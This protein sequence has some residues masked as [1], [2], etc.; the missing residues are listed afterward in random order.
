M[1]A[2]PAWTRGA[3]ASGAQPGAAT[4]EK[5]ILLAE[6]NADHAE[7][8]KHSFRN[9]RVA[10]RIYHVSDGEEALDYL[11][12]RGRY[13]NPADSPRPHLILLDLKMPKVSGI[14]VLQS[15]RAADEYAGVPVVMLSSS[16]ADA[17]VEQAYG[18]HVNSYLV[19][20]LEF[21]AF[22][23]LM[24]DLGYY[25]LQWNNRPSLS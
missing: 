3:S 4:S 25:W 15:I 9:H 23:N 6:D 5:I 14:G 21:D 7:L 11:F 12:R 8:L 24:H 22:S 20:P 16:D 13:A 19:K 2:N 1:N 17:D 10:N 18:L